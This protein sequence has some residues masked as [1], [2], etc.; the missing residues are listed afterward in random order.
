MY[1]LLFSIT[2]WLSTCGLSFAQL[3]VMNFYQAKI[4]EMSQQG[5]PNGQ[6][7]K[8]SILTKNVRNGYLKYAYKPALGYM[9]GV[10]DSPQEMAYFTAQNGRKFV[11][12]VTANKMFIAKDKQ[13]WHWDP[14]SFYE[15]ENGKLVDKTSKYYP[16]SL[17][18]QVNKAIGDGIFWCKLPQIGTSIQ[19]GR[20]NGKAPLIIGELK[21]NVANGTFRFVKS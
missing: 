5:G 13:S 3:S 15:L 4:K 17:Q 8:L 14:P 9:I 20:W 10:T 7:F 11:G 21:Y 18:K 6:R 19:V 1:K 12:I 2:L 16:P